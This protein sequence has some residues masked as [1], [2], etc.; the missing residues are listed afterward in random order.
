MKMRAVSLG[1]TTLLMLLAVAVYSAID[2]VMPG[3]GSGIKLFFAAG[4]TVG[5][6]IASIGLTRRAG[7]G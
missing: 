7:G 5:I 1:I 4:V 3:L 6:C 2:A